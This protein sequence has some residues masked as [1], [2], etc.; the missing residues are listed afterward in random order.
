MQIKTFEEDFARQNYRK[1]GTVIWPLISRQCY[2]IIIPSN[3]IYTASY[4]YGPKITNKN[5]LKQNYKTLST[6]PQD[7]CFVWHQLPV[8]CA[9][10]RV[11]SSSDTFSIN[12][13][14][15]CLIG[16]TAELII[17]GR[18]KGGI[19]PNSLRSVNGNINVWRGQSKLITRQLIISVNGERMLIFN[20]Y[21]NCYFLFWNSLFNK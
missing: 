1:R 17:A 14:I 9:V 6:E 11:N 19:P 18:K 3:S 16:L 20:Y 15:T 10:A 7:E 5:M 2:T 12:S 8:I 4:I 13:T 21:F